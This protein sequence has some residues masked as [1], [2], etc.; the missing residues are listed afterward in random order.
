MNLIKEGR[1]TRASTKAIR[2]LLIYSSLIAGFMATIMSMPQM[3]GSVYAQS[4]NASENAC[5][6]PGYTLSKGQ[7]TAAPIT[8]FTCEPST[9]AGVPVQQSGSR[10]VVAGP[11]SVINEGV[12]DGIEGSTF[13]VIAPP[14]PPPP[15]F[16]P[17]PPPPPP[18]PPTGVC[19]FPATETISCP[20]GV[21]PTEGGKCITK[22]GQ[23]NNP[24]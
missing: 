12:C 3:I 11:E 21:V 8:Q 13:N 19:E 2:S 16:P 4:A 18:L 1:R 5:P 20:G 7:C 23:G 9:L 22:P 15:T 24:T 14:P 17:G 10:C 6:V